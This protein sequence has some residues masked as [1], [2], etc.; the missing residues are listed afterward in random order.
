MDDFRNLPALTRF[1]IADAFMRG[2]IEGAGISETIGPDGEVVLAST[3]DND[4][5]NQN[6]CHLYHYQTTR[7]Q[8]GTGGSANEGEAGSEASSTVSLGQPLTKE[9]YGN[10]LMSVN[11]VSGHLFSEKDTL[12]DR[13]DF[14]L[15]TGKSPVASSV[16]HIWSLDE[17]TANGQLLDEA[18]LFVHN[19]YLKRLKPR[20]SFVNNPNIQLVGGSVG[21]DE[22]TDA[23]IP[24]YEP[25]HLLASYRKFPPIKKES[26]FTLL[27]RW[28][29]SFPT[30]F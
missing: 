5:V 11:I 29:I 14:G 13:Q 2:Q 19:P 16:V 4:L 15:I 24:A 26:Y 9:Q 28:S 30:G 20:T 17:E 23:P 18:G 8:V 3:G 12:L 21:G 22:T 6:P 1:R 27:F 25:G 10:S 7:F